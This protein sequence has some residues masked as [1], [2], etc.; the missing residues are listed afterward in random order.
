MLALIHGENAAPDDLR[1]KRSLIERKAQD[2]RINGVIR[3]V[4]LKEKKVMLV[5]GTPS[6]I[7]L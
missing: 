5:K 4:V 7:V 1:R 3:R 6:Q 2:R